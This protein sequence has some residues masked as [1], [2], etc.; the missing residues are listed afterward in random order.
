MSCITLSL[1]NQKNNYLDIS[2][3]KLYSNWITFWEYSSGNYYQSISGMF[4]FSFFFLIFFF[5]VPFKS[6]ISVALYRLCL[7]ASGKTTYQKS[8]MSVNS[9]IAT[10]PFYLLTTKTCFS[11]GSQDWC[12]LRIHRSKFTSIKVESKSYCFQKHT[13]IHRVNSFFHQANFSWESISFV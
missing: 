1:L 13:W 3:L 9:I 5:I 8:N 10:T 7:R 11:I 12:C 2:C 4:F 6:V